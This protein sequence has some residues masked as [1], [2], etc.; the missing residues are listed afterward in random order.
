MKVANKTL[1]AMV[2]TS[3]GESQMI[4]AAPL[5]GAAPHPAEDT[6]LRALEGSDA[7]PIEGV[8]RRT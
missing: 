2:P 4:G 5:I 3:Y 7:Q 8:E 1:E 6:M